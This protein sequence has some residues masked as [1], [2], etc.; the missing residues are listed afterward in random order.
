[1]PLIFSLPFPVLTTCSL[2]SAKPKEKRATKNKANLAFW[3]VAIV[4]M[5]SIENGA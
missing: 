1:M 3:E 5:E 2:S 4:N